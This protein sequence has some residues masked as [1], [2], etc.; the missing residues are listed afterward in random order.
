MKHHVPLIPAP[1]ADLQAQLHHITVCRKPF[2]KEVVMIVDFGIGP[3]V[4]APQQGKH[5]MCHS[6]NHS[7]T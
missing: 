7:F 5:V 6:T 1:I 3:H 2:M 4:I